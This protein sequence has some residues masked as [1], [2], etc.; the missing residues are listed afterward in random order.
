LH[1][2]SEGMCGG[3]FFVGSEMMKTCSCLKIFEYLNYFIELFKVQSS[4]N[5]LIVT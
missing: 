4:P 5:P 1:S 2:L 3:K